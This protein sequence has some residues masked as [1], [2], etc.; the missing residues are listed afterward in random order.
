MVIGSGIDIIE[1]S[2]VERELTTGSWSPEQGIFTAN[3]IDFCNRERNPSSAYAAVFAAKEATLKAFNLEVRNLSQFREVEV[4]PDPHGKLTLNLQ[5]RILSVSRKLGVQRLALA[6]VTAA[7][8][9]GAFVLLE[10]D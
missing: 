4:L 7:G 2:R 10:S 1:C 3:E 8:L 9:S 6:V 5:G